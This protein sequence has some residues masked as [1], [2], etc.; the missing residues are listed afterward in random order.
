MRINSTSPTLTFRNYF[1]TEMSNGNYWD[2]GVLEVSISGDFLDA[3][4]P[5][6]G[7]TFVQG[8]YTG[9]ID[10]EAGNPLAGRMAWSGNSGGYIDTVI[11]L[12]PNLNGHTVTL[13]FRFG[14]DVSG[15]APGWRIDDLHVNGAICQ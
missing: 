10:R 9:Q 2:G 5:G 15:S 11:N 7:G 14:T 4:D 6:I 12:G 1:N 8:G 3:T 13:R